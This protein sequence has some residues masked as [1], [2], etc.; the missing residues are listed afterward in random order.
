M[1][2][3]AKFKVTKYK[4]NKKKSLYKLLT[5]AQLGRHQFSFI[6]EG[7]TYNPDTIQISTYKEMLDDGGILFP[8]L[9]FKIPIQNMR[10]QL[11]CKS[12]EIKKFATENLERIWKHLMRNLSTALEFGYSGNE[13]RFEARDGQWWLKIPL[14]MD[15]QYLTIKVTEDGSFDGLIQQL[16]WGNTEEVTIP[17]E[18]CFVY[19]HD[20]R[21][22]NL[23]G[24]SRIR[25]A[26]RYWFLDKYI[27]ENHGLYTE[28]LA[29]ATVL[30]KAPI[31]ESQIGLDSENSPIM[32][33]N[34]DLIQEIVESV[35][36]SGGVSM[37]SEAG[38]NIELLEE[39]A[40]KVYDFNADHDKMDQLKARA[41][42]V[43]EE[44]AFGGGGSYAKANIHSEW[45]SRAVESLANDMAK[46][47][48]LPYL[49][50]PLIR[51]NFSGSLPKIDFEFE[52]LDPYV[53]N[54]NKDVFLK[55]FDNEPQDIKPDVIELAKRFRV[56]LTSE[57]GKISFDYK[58]EKNPERSAFIALRKVYNQGVEKGKEEYSFEGYVEMPDEDHD[59][60][61]GKAKEFIQL[62][63]FSKEKEIKLGHFDLLNLIY[64]LGI[65]RSKEKAGDLVAK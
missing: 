34:L 19:T 51:A 29:I 2:K 43:F 13:K 63:Q 40:G 46:G 17:K 8:L 7:E 11:V 3:T 32:V 6:K 58:E 26:Y 36:S 45:L 28:K 10:W 50:D 61:K 48:I 49:V 56:P 52:P 37:P 5:S 20:K 57:G 18:K 55:T 39:K 60:L 23:Y 41:I 59:F 16:P 30:G 27:F 14:D 35:R 22:G 31:G 15:P 9:I 62:K 53:R 33:D 54:I 25:S 4:K 12:Q 38:W 47:Y 24:R 1:A 64:D 65:K 21:F 42:F 44:V